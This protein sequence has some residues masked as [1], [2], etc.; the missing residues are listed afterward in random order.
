MPIPVVCALILHDGKIMLAQRPEGKH[1]ALKWEFPGGK[2]EPGEMPETAIARELH[3]ELGCEVRVVAALP[4]SQ[5]AYDR[6]MVEMIPFVCTL[7]PGRSPPQPHEHAALQWVQPHELRQ[8]DLAPADYPVV[9][10]FDAWWAEQK[11]SQPAN[12]R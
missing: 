11:T 3:E 8:H 9:D 4:R 5:H 6:G 10:T 7:V 12:L 2:V 1:L